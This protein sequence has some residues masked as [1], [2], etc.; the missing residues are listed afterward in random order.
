MQFW[1]VYDH[2]TDMPD[3]F[4]ARRWDVLKGKAMPVATDQVFTAG[5]L[6]EVRS[7]IPPG[8]YRLPRWEADDDK[9]VE[10][11]L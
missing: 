1:V 9:I 5:T 11:W 3:F 7:L 2:P 8:L 6:Q 10:V 4:V